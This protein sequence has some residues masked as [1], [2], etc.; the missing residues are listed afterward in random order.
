V[1]YKALLSV[2]FFFCVVYSLDAQ[3]AW[4][5]SDKTDAFSGD[6]YSEFILA[7]HYIQAPSKGEDAIPQITLRCRDRPA[8][9]QKVFRGDF[10]NAHLS[11]GTVLDR[12]TSG[13]VSVVFRLDDGKPQTDVWA[14]ST[15]GTAIF[16]NDVTLDTLLW[17]H[18]MPHK[19]NTSPPVK[20]IVL[21]LDEAFAGKIVMQFDMP[22]PSVVSEMCGVT[23]HR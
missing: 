11:T 19:E 2:V 14:I 21:M 13:N 3:S 9:K 7:G 16:F 5:R 17:G 18:F 8:N 20:K 10:L 15:D 6:P 1:R 23:I 4:I 22:D 12:A